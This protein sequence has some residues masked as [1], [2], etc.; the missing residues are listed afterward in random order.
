MSST[1]ASWRICK[2]H[3]GKLLQ[4]PCSHEHLQI[5]SERQTMRNVL[6]RSP[7]PP[8]KGAEQLPRGGIP[9]VWSIAKALVARSNAQLLL[10]VLKGGYSYGTPETFLP[11]PG[12]PFLLGRQFGYD[13]IWKHKLADGETGRGSE[14]HAC[15]S[16]Q[17]RLF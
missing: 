7:S 4:M 2:K 9:N 12:I 5:F 13:T 1:A 16:A 6:L 10:Y 3:R 14:F 17:Q 8:R 15:F 11:V